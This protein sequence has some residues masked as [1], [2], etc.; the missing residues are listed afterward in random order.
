MTSI[1]PLLRTFSFVAQDFD[2]ANF[3]PILFLEAGIFFLFPSFSSREFV[4]A[5]GGHRSQEKPHFFPSFPF[6]GWCHDR[7]ERVISVE[8]A[9]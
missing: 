3:P 6:I 8:K 1:P 4:L 2:L 5:C 7:P 9:V